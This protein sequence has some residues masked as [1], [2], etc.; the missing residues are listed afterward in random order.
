L[1]GGVPPA[2]T[3]IVVEISTDGSGR[4]HPTLQEFGVLHAF[5]V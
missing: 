1:R 2:S 4:E 5:I 3:P